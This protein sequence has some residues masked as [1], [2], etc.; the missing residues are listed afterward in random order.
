MGKNHKQTDTVVLWWNV[1]YKIGCKGCVWLL[2]LPALHLRYFANSFSQCLLIVFLSRERRKKL[3]APVSDQ[4]L[5]SPGHT[6]KMNHRFKARHLLPLE[7]LSCAFCRTSEWSEKTNKPKKCEQ[8]VGSNQCG[9]EEGIH[10]PPI[11]A[12]SREAGHWLS[13]LKSLKVIPGHG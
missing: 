8:R 13:L 9:Q 3:T 1:T 10:W 5:M 7:L 6:S 2:K 4:R 12:I 11:W